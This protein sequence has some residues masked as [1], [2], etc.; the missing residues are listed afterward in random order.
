MHRS[1][2][3]VLTLTA[4]AVAVTACS[5][6]DPV[7]DLPRILRFEAAPATIG[8]GE[9]AELSWEATGAQRFSIDN[10]VGAVSGGSAQVRPTTTTTYTLT[11]TNDRGSTTAKTTVAVTTSGGTDLSGSLTTRTLTLAGSPYQVT[12]DLFVP[13]GSRLT[14]EPGVRLVFMGHFKLAV[15]GRI[16]AQGTA[17][18][19]IVFTASDPATG[20]NGLRL[21]ATSDAGADFLEHCIL[22]YGNKDNGENGAGDEGSYSE[23]AGGALWIGSRANVNVNDNEFRFNKAPAF[24]GALMLIAPTSGGVATGNIFHDNECTGPRTQFGGVGGAVNTAH[25]PA[26]NQWT[27]RGGEFRDNRAPEGGALY[28]FDSNVTIDSIAM[29]GNTP[30]NWA[31]PEPQRLTVI[32]TPL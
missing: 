29:S 6:P 22:E 8:P 15:H 28:F 13:E 11:A 18:H 27:F 25:L 3:L 20:W 16:T 32:N 7:P 31:T 4:T 21:A 5:S 26:S 1:R 24:G 9:S 19:P 10:G 2:L 12:G 14:I 30:Q 17:S 23:N